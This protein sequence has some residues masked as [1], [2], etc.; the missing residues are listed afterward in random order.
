ME[1]EYGLVQHLKADPTL[2]ALL[3]GRIY[4]GIAPQGAS[5]PRLTYNRI[6][7][8]DDQAMDGPAGLPQTRLQIDV[9]GDSHD[10]VR[11]IV[12]RLLAL[13]NG[14]G[15][16]WGDAWVA[17]SERE[18]QRTSYEPP[19]DASDQGVYRESVDLVVAYNED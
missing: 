11:A 18:D 1:V 14:T 7:T 2:D 17:C 13:L 16:A 19:V 6:S 9:W 15:G 10:A 8:Q 5:L 3:S 4:P 12:A